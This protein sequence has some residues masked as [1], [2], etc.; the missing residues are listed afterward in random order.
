[1]LE[2]LADYGLFLLK[3]AT[4]MAAIIVVIGVAT[5]AGKRANA[6]TLEVEKLND[7]YRELANSLKAA[8]LGKSETKALRKAE[9]ARFTR[10][11]RHGTPARG[12]G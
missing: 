5:E 7:K 9:K 2:L 6:D 1:M 12:G 11:V 10:C 3:V 8:V 4:I